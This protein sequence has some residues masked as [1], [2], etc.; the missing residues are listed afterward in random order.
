MAP[1]KSTGAKKTAE[2]TPNPPGTPLGSKTGN[3]AL[4]TLV[5]SLSTIGKPVTP[6]G[7]TDYS[8]TAIAKDAWNEY[9]RDTPRRLKSI[10]VFLV[11]LI[12]VGVVQFL[13]C[14]LVGNYPFNA[15][16]AGFGATVGQFVL[17]GR[18]SAVATTLQSVTDTVCSCTSHTDQQGQPI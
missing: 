16:L 9:A 11:F 13:Y 1:R 4:D 3:D 6:T 5:S 8:Y 10:D 2:S 17:T 12:Y 15:F 14:A 7:K 18:W